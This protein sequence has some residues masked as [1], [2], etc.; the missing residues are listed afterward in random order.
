MI[1]V[2]IPNRNHGAY[3]ARGLQG[4]I[5]EAD[6]VRVVDDASEDD[7]REIVRRLQGRHPN[8]RLIGKNVPCG[9]LANL[10]EQLSD[11]APGHVLFHAADDYLL[12]GAMTRLRTILQEFPHVGLVVWDL[13]F[14][15]AGKQRPSH[16]YRSGQGGGYFP[17]EIVAERFRGLPFV[18][19]ALFRVDALQALG[20]QPEKLAWHADHHT[21]WILGLRYG[22]YYLNETLGVL[23][24]NPGSYSSGM[25]GEKQK[26]VFEE[27]VREWNLP[28]YDDVREGLIRGQAIAVFPG[29]LLKNL[30][31]I[32]GGTAYWTPGLRRLLW[33]RQWRHHFRHPLPESWKKKLR[34]IRPH[35]AM[36]LRSYL[37]RPV[38]RLYRKVLGKTGCGDIPLR[39]ADSTPAHCQAFPSAGTVF[40]KGERNLPEVPSSIGSGVVHPNLSVALSAGTAGVWVARLEKAQVHGPSVGVTTGDRTFLPDVSIEWNKIPEDHGVMRRFRLP[41]ARR[42]GGMTLLLASTG[43]DTYHHWMMDVQ[44]RI[45][46]LQAAGTDLRK[47]DHFLVNGKG[48]PFQRDSLRCLGVPAE[49]CI[50]LTGRCRFQCETLILPSLPFPTS[51]PSREACEFLR[52]FF[53]SGQ[54]GPTQKLLVDRGGGVSRQVRKWE[55]IRNKLLSLGFVEFDPGQASLE[56]QAATFGRAGIVVGAHGAALTNLVFCQPGTRVLEMFGADYVNPCYRNLCAAAGLEHHAVV[57]VVEAGQPAQLELIDATREIRGEPGLVVELAEKLLRAG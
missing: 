33:F 30:P 34:K 16:G 41:P 25:F 44:P 36:N 26:Q 40:W 1:T 27:T 2:L 24:E 29:N 15:T 17:P 22:I 50:P 3:L 14:E 11:L 19:Q 42:L 35:E 46:L 5:P 18:G 39:M 20:G 9:L 23:Q 12:P 49:K 52:R 37:R 8:L 45:E 10:N 54:P 53:G 56:E 6:E 31:R 57:D 7:S 13:A 4:V 55:E 43:G 38:L 28:K 48:T 47:V 21:A 32:P 51:R